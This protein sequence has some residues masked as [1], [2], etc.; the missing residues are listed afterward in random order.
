MA[1]CGSSTPPTLPVAES[2]RTRTLESPDRLQEDDQ[3]DSSSKWLFSQAIPYERDDLRTSTG[4]G[5][6]TLSTVVNKSSRSS[7]ESHGA[8]GRTG[9][10][11]WKAK[12]S[13]VVSLC[14]LAVWPPYM[15]WRFSHSRSCQ[16]LA[17]DS[18]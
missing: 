7:T 6:S 5:H 4:R 1:E 15:K 11:F 2:T 12:E 14:F 17:R 18:S 8:R 10:L 13:S 16:G 3:A 9:S